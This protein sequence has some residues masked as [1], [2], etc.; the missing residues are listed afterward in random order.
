MHFPGRAPRCWPNRS[1]KSRSPAPGAN[2]GPERIAPG[3]TPESLANRRITAEV[4]PRRHA[5]RAS[6][7]RQQPGMPIQQAPDGGVACLMLLLVGKRRAGSPRPG[8]GGRVNG[9]RTGD[10]PMGQ[11]E[12]VPSWRCYHTTAI[13]RCGQ[14]G[15]IFCGSC[16][17]V[18]IPRRVSNR[19][20]LVTACP[21]CR[22][23]ALIDLSLET[24]PLTAIRRPTGDAVG[25]VPVP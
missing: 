4:F 25:R 17:P 8:E 11:A 13:T 5:G 12:R 24:A 21:H 3:Y 18:L 16:H 2:S 10:N 14:C 1:T 9:R 7:C 6:G 15:L 20:E 19:L 22:G 23:T